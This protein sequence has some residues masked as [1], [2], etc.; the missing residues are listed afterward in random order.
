MIAAN[1]DYGRDAVPNRPYQVFK[2]V[3]VLCAQQVD[4]IGRGQINAKSEKAN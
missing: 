2:T 4:W 1:S 3:S